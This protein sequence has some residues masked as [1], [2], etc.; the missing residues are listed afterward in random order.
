M[1]LAAV[2]GALRAFVIRRGRDPEGMELKAMVPVS[3]RADAERGALGNRVAAM[4]A[5]LPLYATDARERFAIVHEAMGGLK[6][7]GQ[8]VGAEVLTRLAGLRRADRA[9]PGRRG[10]RPAS[11]SSTSS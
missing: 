9:R 7:S 2:A 4:Y 6:E 1:V 8:A 10:C 11:A 3:V 5:P